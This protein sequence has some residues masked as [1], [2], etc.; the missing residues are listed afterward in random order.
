MNFSF[1]LISAKVAV[2]LAKQ[3]L[4]DATV[5]LHPSGVTVDD[6]KGNYIFICSLY[7]LI[8]SHLL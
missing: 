3:K 7:L 5:L 6:I 8:P 1:L 4:V 2:E